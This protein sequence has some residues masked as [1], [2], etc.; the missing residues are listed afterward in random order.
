VDFGR[1]G[2]LEDPQAGRRRVVH[3]LIFTAVYSRHMFVWLSFRQDLTAVIAG[4][5]AAWVFFGGVFAV[6]IPDN[7]AAVVDKAH[8]LEPRLNRVGF[9]NLVMLSD[10]HRHWLGW[11][12]HAACSY[13]WISPPR[14]L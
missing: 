11:C 14:T 2:L 4:F 6:V 5:E 7:M 10:L 3:A 1:M 13:S 12:L 8:P 9:H